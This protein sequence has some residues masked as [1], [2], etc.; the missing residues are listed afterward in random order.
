V[1]GSEPLSTRAAGGCPGRRLAAGRWAAAGRVGG[2]R[3]G[4][5]ERRP[6]SARAAMGRAGGSKAC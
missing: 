3:G 5:R 6:L 1:P 2:V 4:A